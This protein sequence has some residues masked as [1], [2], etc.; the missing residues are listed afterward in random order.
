MKTACPKSTSGFTLIELLVTIA[1]IAILIG[2]VAGVAGVAN[3][4]SAESQVRAEM[5][6]IAFALDNFRA[7][8]GR[9][10]T[11]NYFFS[12][13]NELIGAKGKRVSTVDPWGN[14]YDYMPST[15]FFELKSE[16]PSTNKSEDDIH[17]TM[18]GL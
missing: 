1:I 2:I 6:D 5:Q 12:S 14:R 17:H 18:D 10:P 8:Y 16:G 7:R 9:Y 15:N 4:K 11:E 3:R 13:T